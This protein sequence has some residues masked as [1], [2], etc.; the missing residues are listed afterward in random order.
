L[1]KR[2][3]VKQ[4]HGTGSVKQ[5]PLTT[6]AMVD[7]WKDAMI[8]PMTESALTVAGGETKS[9]MQPADEFRYSGRCFCGTY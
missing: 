7:N 3:L 5:D 1:K 8:K 6:G 2:I 4:D 9:K